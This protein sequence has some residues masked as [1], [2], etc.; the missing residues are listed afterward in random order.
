MHGNRWIRSTIKGGQKEKVRARLVGKKITVAC[1]IE[2][3]D[4]HLKY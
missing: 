3:T 2:Y 1:H 4:A